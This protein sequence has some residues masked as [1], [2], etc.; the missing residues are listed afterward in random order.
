MPVNRAHVY[1]MR[2]ATL[3]RIRSADLT[4]SDPDRIDYIVPLGVPAA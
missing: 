2:S 1:L 4:E 3:D